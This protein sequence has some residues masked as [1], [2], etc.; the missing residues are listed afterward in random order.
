MVVRERAYGGAHCAVHRAWKA[1]QLPTAC[2]E[3]PGYARAGGP[4]LASVSA[5]RVGPGDAVHPEGAAWGAGRHLSLRAV[6]PQSASGRRGSIQ[7][8]DGRQRH[9]AHMFYEIPR[10]GDKP[11]QRLFRLVLF[12]DLYCES[13]WLYKY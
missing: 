7:A 5:A 6:L 9:G 10:C 1:V 12:G 4:A 13:Y 11:D 8:C 3:K 2:G